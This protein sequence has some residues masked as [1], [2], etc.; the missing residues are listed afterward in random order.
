MSFGKALSESSIPR[1]DI[2][3]VTKLHPRYL[4]YNDT[5]KAIEMSLEN[6]NTSYIDL[7]LIHSMECD[8]FLLKCEEGEP[9]GTWKES[10]RAME[11]AKRDGKIRSLG[12]SNIYGKTIYQLLDWSM[13]PVSVIQNW[14]DPLNQDVETRQICSKYNIRFMGYSTLGKIFTVV[15]SPQ[16]FCCFCFLFFERLIW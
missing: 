2:F 1:E 13:E 9:H 14:F 15:Y 12:F 3:V 4:G 11:K 16:P 8:D 10:W 7:Y 5:L 6:L